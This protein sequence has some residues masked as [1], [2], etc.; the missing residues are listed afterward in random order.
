MH[1]QVTIGGEAIEA[2][3]PRNQFQS[4]IAARMAAAAASARKIPAVQASPRRRRFAR[5]SGAASA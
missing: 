4:Q 5:V 1:R 2:T 3:G